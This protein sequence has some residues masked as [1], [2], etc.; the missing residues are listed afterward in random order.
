MHA[1]V[2]FNATLL[3][4]HTTMQKWEHELNCRFLQSR[5][6][7]LSPATWLVLSMCWEK[8]QKS[9]PS[10]FQCRQTHA[11]LKHSA[12]SGKVHRRAGLCRVQEITELQALGAEAAA[13]VDRVL[14]IAESENPEPGDRTVSGASRGGF[15]AFC[16]RFSVS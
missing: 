1:C 15:F 12:R 9:P 11:G 5:L 7:L 2:C 6:G 14:I 8:R 10:I 13:A 3:L 16:S 4:P